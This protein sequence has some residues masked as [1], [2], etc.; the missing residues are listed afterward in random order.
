MMGFAR[1]QPILRV[2][3][4]LYRLPSDVVA[5]AREAVEAKYGLHPVRLTPA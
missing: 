3:R 5:K 2:L 4:V 1:A